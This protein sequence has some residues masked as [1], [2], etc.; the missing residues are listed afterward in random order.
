[1]TDE[2]AVS[3]RYVALR[4]GDLGR[5]RA[6]YEGLLGLNVCGEKPGEFLQ[7]AVGDAAVCVDVADGEEPPAAIFAVRGLD[8]LCRRLEAA[9]VSVERSSEEGVGDYV[10]AHDPDGHE[11]V[12]E[13]AGP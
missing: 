1:M 12:F 5:S 6:F 9:G 2:Y 3:L 4:T 7:F 11:L 13:P 10:V 8:Q